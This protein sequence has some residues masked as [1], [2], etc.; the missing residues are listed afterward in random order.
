MD[1][2]RGGE[3]FLFNRFGDELE[4]LPHSTTAEAE[5]QEHDQELTDKIIGQAKLELGDAIRHG[6]KEMKKAVDTVKGDERYL[7]LNTR[8]EK[9]ESGINDVTQNYISFKSKRLVGI[10]KGI[11]KSDAVNKEQLDTSIS[12]SKRIANL[13]DSPTPEVLKLKG[14]RRIG[15]VSRSKDDYDVVVRIE[16]TEINNKLFDFQ[17]RINGLFDAIH[18]DIKTLKKSSIIS[19]EGESYS[20]NVLSNLAEDKQS[21]YSGISDD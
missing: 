6:L 3:R 20:H 2:N 5:L 9:I 1:G 8:L 10:S 17:Q 21:D 11:D 12:S 13:F 16:M 4:S 7:R 15:N 18:S 19:P 14:H